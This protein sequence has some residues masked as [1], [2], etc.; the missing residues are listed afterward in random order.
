[1]FLCK[2]LSVDIFIYINIIYLYLS[3]YKIC[4]YAEGMF[5]ATVCITTHI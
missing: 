3:I 5:L 1:M 4:V 2:V